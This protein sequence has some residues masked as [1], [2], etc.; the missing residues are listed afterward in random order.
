MWV[1]T[2]PDP[3]LGRVDH[4]HQRLAAGA[5][6]RVAVRRADDAWLEERWADPETRVLVVAGTR[7]RPVDGAVDWVSP[8][9][10]PRACGS[11]WGSR[12]AGPG[13]RSSHRRR[14]RRSTP[15]GT[16]S[17]DCCPTSPTRG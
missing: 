13:S 16:R 14:A 7:V 11:C 9:D 5:H 15:G 10:A 6:D 1:L 12:T 3:S 2:W 17:A 4:A 8:A